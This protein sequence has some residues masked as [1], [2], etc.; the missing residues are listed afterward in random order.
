MMNPS[1]GKGRKMSVRRSRTSQTNRTN[2]ETTTEA[3]TKAIL[4]EWWYAIAEELFER[5]CVVTELDEEQKVALRA[6][7]LRPNDFQ[8]IV[9]GLEQEEEEEEEE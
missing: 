1:L 3:M 8:I 6:V 5:V 9:E 2:P 4:Y 7:S